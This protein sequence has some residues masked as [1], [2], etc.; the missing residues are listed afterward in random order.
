MNIFHKILAGAVALLDARDLSLEF[1]QGNH[2]EKGQPLLA[3]I[4]EFIRQILLDSKV[5]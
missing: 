4:E 5:A 3:E 1:I 2:I